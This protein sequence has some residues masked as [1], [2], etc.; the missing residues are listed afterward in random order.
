MTIN[1]HPCIIYT[2]KIVVGCLISNYPAVFSG[3]G[4]S[5]IA[6]IAWNTDWPFL[7]AVS[8]RC[9]PDNQFSA[10]TNFASKDAIFS[11]SVI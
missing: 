10:E 6:T 9:H 4:E 3:I 8:I 7:M 5:T 2:P 11:E 1:M